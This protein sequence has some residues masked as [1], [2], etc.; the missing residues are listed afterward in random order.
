V[1]CVEWAGLDLEPRR[2]DL[3]ARRGSI[4]L[5]STDFS[6]VGNLINTILISPSMSTVIRVAWREVRAR[7]AFSSG[8]VTALSSGVDP[9]LG[10]AL[11]TRGLLR[12][13]L[14]V[15]GRRR[16]VIVIVRA[17]ARH[18]RSQVRHHGLRDGFHDVAAELAVFAG[19]LLLQAEAL[20]LGHVGAAEVPDLPRDVEHDLLWAPV[21]LHGVFGLANV[22]PGDI[23]GAVGGEGDA[24]GHLLPPPLGVEQGI[25]PGLLARIDVDPSLLHLR[26]DLGPD[27][28]L[29]VPHPPDASADGTTQHAE[30]VGPLAAAAPPG[31][32]QPPHIT[33][34]GEP[35]VGA[36][37]TGGAAV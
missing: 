6:S 4:P 20:V 18:A 9:L 13:Q 35:L 5:D 34:S 8:V 33:V 25:I 17:R 27:V 26:V 37:V 1:S 29:G 24:V 30:H 7:T 10:T 11:A 21:P 19:V 36:A 3:V 31:L 15:V 2:R 32:E 23:R 22:P 16:S 14:L 12:R 28:V